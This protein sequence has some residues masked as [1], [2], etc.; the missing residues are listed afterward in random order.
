M[1]L[2]SEMTNDWSGK[3]IAC[4]GYARSIH[5]TSR[6]ACWKM[7]L[8]VT[9]TGDRGLPFTQK[10][11]FLAFASEIGSVK[12]RR[13]SFCL[14]LIA[15][16]R[17]A[18]QQLWSQGWLEPRIVH[19]QQ[20]STERASASTTKE[21]NVGKSARCFGVLVM[22]APHLGDQVAPITTPLMATL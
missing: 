9:V 6:G 17:S 20:A 2:P 13:P 22:G 19:R 16:S 10:L 11:L 1:Y 21:S 7:S 15:D 12:R 8:R 3:P 4:A 18:T 14:F 5:G